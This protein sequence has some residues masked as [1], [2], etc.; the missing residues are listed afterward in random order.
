MGLSRANRAIGRSAIARG[1]RCAPRARAG[2]R[3]VARALVTLDEHGASRAGSARALARRPIQARETYRGHDESTALGG[4]AHLHSLE[5]GSAAGAGAG[6][7]GPRDDAR[8]HR[9][10]NNS[11]HF[12]WCAAGMCCGACGYAGARA[13]PAFRVSRSETNATGLSEP[14]R[15]CQRGVRASQKRESNFPPERV[16]GL[17]GIHDRGPRNLAWTP[18]G[19]KFPD[20]SIVAERVTETS[21]REAGARVSSATAS[22]FRQP[23]DFRGCDDET[24]SRLF[25]RGSSRTHGSESQVKIKS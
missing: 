12:Y 7:G 13:R 6:G 2:P 18:P 23:A 24:R 5:V 19:A 17:F 15:I 16:L 22:A 4:L 9:G 10:G 14:H 11:G 1:A 8:G 25:S 20:W 3:R 21:L